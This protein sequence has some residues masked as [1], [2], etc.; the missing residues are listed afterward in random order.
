MVA[1]PAVLA[2]RSVMR[3]SLTDRE[4]PPPRTRSKADS[5]RPAAAER[6]QRTLADFPRVVRTASR[7]RA[8]WLP[9]S[10]TATISP[11]VSLSPTVVFAISWRCNKAPHAANDRRRASIV[12]LDVS[13]YLL[14]L[15][16]PRR[17]AFEQSLRGVRIGQDCSERP[18]QLVG[19]RSRQLAHRRDATYVRQRRVEPLLFR[20]PFAHRV[21]VA[22]RADVAKKVAGQ[23]EPRHPCAQH[24]TIVAIV[25]S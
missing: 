2:I 17:T 8:R 3:R 9:A 14:Q 13:Q 1:A 23:R 15:I 4:S 21:D 10:S 24:P 18:I 20:L 6:D 12:C 5:T 11:T 25:P 7:P 19:E 16:E 22:T